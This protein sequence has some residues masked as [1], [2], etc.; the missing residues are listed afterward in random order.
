MLNRKEDRPLSFFKFP[1]GRALAPS[2]NSESMRELLQ[3]RALA[4]PLRSWPVVPAC[5]PHER[6]YFY[7]LIFGRRTNPEC[8]DCT[9]IEC[10][11]DPAL[12]IP[13][14]W[15][16][17]LSLVFVKIIF[18]IFLDHSHVVEYFACG[19]GDQGQI[20]PIDSM[21]THPEPPVETASLLFLRAKTPHIWRSELDFNAEV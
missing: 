11:F 14:F 13:L 19:L 12:G 2:I 8:L 3:R 4:T 17:N 20:L 9:S 18:R 16:G 5:A 21:S 6:K 1:S 15:R 7:S 10:S